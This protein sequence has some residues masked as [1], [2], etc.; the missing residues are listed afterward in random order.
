MNLPRHRAVSIAALLV[1]ALVQPLTAGTAGAADGWEAGRA[2]TSS[3]GVVGASGT[4]IVLADWVDSSPDPDTRQMS[5]RL[6]RSVDDGATFS[7]VQE[8]AGGTPPRFGQATGAV[9]FGAG[10][11]FVVS[12]TDAADGPA[13]RF[14]RHEMEGGWSPPVLL[15]AAGCAVLPTRAVVAASDTSVLVA[16]ACGL[17]RSVDGGG[18]FEPVA[19]PGPLASVEAVTAT[20]RGFSLLY[21]ATPSGSSDQ[22]LFSSASV[23]DGVS[24]EAPVQLTPAAAELVDST[25][26]VRDALTGTLVAV[27]HVRKDPQQSSSS[28]LRLEVRRSGD[29][30][31]TWGAASVLN[32][33]STS[34]AGEQGFPPLPAATESGLDLTAPAYDSSGARRWLRWTSADGGATW[35]RGPAP[36]DVSSDLQGFD[37]PASSAG[38]ALAHLLREGSYTRTS[39]AANGT[40]PD[41]VLPPTLALSPA[42]ISA[43]QTTVV[44]YRGTPGSTVDILSRT[45]PAT[46]FSKIGTVTLGA[47]GIGTSSHRP[48]KNT[49]ITARTAAG[50]LSETAPIIAVRSVASFNA[51]RV[52]T[53]TYT[54]TGRVYPALRNRLVNLYRNGV[55]AGQGRCDATGI[56]VIT[57]T[58]GAG[59]FT[60][61]VRTPNDQDNLGTTSRQL[62]VAIS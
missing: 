54:F 2:L 4:D 19:A 52:G 46:L 24:F 22:R 20:D 3:G 32:D 15:R 12:R 44:T 16:D 27:T 6:Q 5:L 11:A 37:R 29:H 25:R 50:Q 43:G 38:G 51:K 58:L 17:W 39:G 56:Y 9:V 53:R 7:T 55:L 48:Q 28:G 40:D 59:T 1:G 45:Q 49:R 30:G 21:N 35:T 8:P 23:D 31:R 13:L 57:R 47:D 10:V 34:A 33:G 26:A 62:R 14:D 61:Q 60:F 18:S 36:A 42:T 41:A